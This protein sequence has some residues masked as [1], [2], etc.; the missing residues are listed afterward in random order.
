MNAKSLK[1]KPIRWQR[2]QRGAAAVSMTLSLLPLMGMVTLALDG[3]RYIQE[4]G[5]IRDGMESASLALASA[6]NQGL[7][8]EQAQ[9]V[10]ESY[11]QSYLRS[12]S[13]AD[14]TDPVVKVESR[15]P[16]QG[17]NQ[18]V[19]YYLTVETYHDSWFSSDLFA[20]FADTVTMKT[21]GLARNYSQPVEFS[22][23]DIVL[24]SEFSRHMANL[25]PDSSSTKLALMKD[26]V[27]QISAAV[28][29]DEEDGQ[30]TGARVAVVPFDLRTQE[31]STAVDWELSY[32]AS[33]LRYSDKALSG[34][35]SYEQINW[36]SWATIPAKD[37]YGCA[38]KG[39]NCM[40]EDSQRGKV[41]SRALRDIL[42]TSKGDGNVAVGPYNQTQ[43]SPDTPSYINFG[44]TVSDMF[45]PKVDT[46]VKM[47]DANPNH[48]S[49]TFFRGGKDRPRMFDR[50]W[51][52]DPN[53]MADRHICH[54]TFYTIPLTT[55]ASDVAA[56]DE[57]ELERFSDRDYGYSALY[58]GLLRGAQILN[59][60]SNIEDF[61]ER[62]KM[63]LML[64]EGTEDPHPN[65]FAQLVGTG[66][67]DEIRNKFNSEDNPI[68]LGVVGFGLNASALPA[69]TQ[70][71]G[72][73]NIFDIGDLNEVIDLVTQMSQSG[74]QG[75]TTSDG[76]S[77]I[78]QIR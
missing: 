37:I 11:L 72:E 64:T 39:E 50:L 38:E 78:V 28:L 15:F 20:S 35:L 74:S 23:M 14:D 71:V 2:A 56:V 6:N 76:I 3:S 63:I 67:C 70:C 16:T 57:M 9:A 59:E 36:F 53:Y 27:Q 47:V 51:H 52:G 18:Y 49:V 17:G 4:S 19:E 69:L 32:C 24:V 61:E 29:S 26:A 30:P 7:S 54:G 22:G 43:F 10:A 60:G 8:D 34:G 58:Q 12:S 66:M 33:Q 21:D 1:R 31:L 5:R 44:L 62:P 77:R 68:Y 45:R 46:S 55:E 25:N 48:P 73:D 13:K 75:A 40:L 41:S 42:N 65:T